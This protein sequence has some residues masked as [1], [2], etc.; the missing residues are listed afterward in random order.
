MD[1]SLSKHRYDVIF[2]QISEVLTSILLQ[3]LREGNK[4]IL[5]HFRNLPNLKNSFG[6]GNS[7]ISLKKN[8]LELQQPCIK[9]FR[10]VT[11]SGVDAP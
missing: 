8:F 4:T 1:E 10:L 11:H 6:R 3:I 5:K 9:S 2:A 7:N